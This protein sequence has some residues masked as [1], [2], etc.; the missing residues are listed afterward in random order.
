MHE[1]DYFKKIILYSDDM[2]DDVYH[3]N[4]KRIYLVNFFYVVIAD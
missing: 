4:V 2:T 1:I 3:L